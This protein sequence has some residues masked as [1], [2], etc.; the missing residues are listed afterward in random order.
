MPKLFSS[1]FLD[2]IS[3]LF[4]SLCFESQFKKLPLWCFWNEIQKLFSFL[5]GRLHF[6]N[7]SLVYLWNYK[8]KRFS[9]LFF[10]LKFKNFLWSRFGIEVQKTVLLFIVL[11]W[12]PKIVLFF[13][14][15]SIQIMIL[16]SIFG[17]AIQ[18]LFSSLILFSVFQIF[19]FLYLNFKS[20]NVLS[21]LFWSAIQKLLSLFFFELQKLVSVLIR[22]IAF[23]NCNWKTVLFFMFEFQFKKNWFASQQMFSSLFCDL[24]FENCFLFFFWVASQNMFS[25]LLVW[26]TT[27]NCAL[28][29][30]WECI[31]K[32][33]SSLFLELQFRNDSLQYIFQC[34]SKYVLCSIFAIAIQ[35]RCSSLTFELQVKN[36]CFLEYLNSKVKIVLLYFLNCNSRT[37]LFSVFFL[38]NSK[39]VRSYTCYLEFKNCSPLYLLSCKSKAV[40]SSFL[41]IG[42]QN[43][44]SCS[45]FGIA[46][47]KTVLFSIQKTFL[48][49]IFWIALQK[50]ICFLSSEL[51][52]KTVLFSFL[53]CKSKNYSS[54]KFLKCSQK[55]VLFSILGIV[56]PK[57]FSS[58]F[59][60]LHFKNSSLLS[61][62]HCNSQT[63][64][65]SPCGIA[66]HKI[67]FSLFLE[68]QVENCSRLFLELLFS[69]W[70]CNATTVLFSIFW[71]GNQKMFPFLCFEFHIKMFFFAIFIL[72]D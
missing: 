61:F 42:I 10:A 19:S 57:L 15:K 36:C 50:L 64:L 65:I 45:F 14:S 13:F 51:Q 11:N 8:A 49:C 69:F 70:N 17:I 32:L 63:V 33:F 38:C 23:L 30:I 21:F 26:V 16:L 67:F 5:V 29:Y 27:Q 18:K 47:P 59:F 54:F 68:L 9:S 55:T 6:K 53:S 60:E 12:N 44:F 66:I 1:V 24:P 35:K 34:N 72:Q 40:L 58:W 3:K 46:S 39:T 28:F 48:F 31:A 56:I 71:S 52:V 25:P 2:W 4:S 62:W 43:F 37:G 20:K 7:C 41:G 22:K